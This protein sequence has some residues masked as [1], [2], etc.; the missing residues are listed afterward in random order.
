LEAAAA[1]VPSLGIEVKAID[2][3]HHY[4]RPGPRQIIKDEIFADAPD[5]MLNFKNVSRN[6]SIKDF[7]GKIQTVC[8]ELMKWPKDEY[9]EYN[10][11]FIGDYGATEKILKRV[12]ENL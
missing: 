8:Q 7:F 1:R 11:K 3:L 6:V 4:M 12:S 5:S 2:K 9:K 10:E